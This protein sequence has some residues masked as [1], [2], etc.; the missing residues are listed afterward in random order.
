MVTVRTL[1]PQDVYCRRQMFGNSHGDHGDSKKTSKRTSSNPTLMNGYAAI[2][3]FLGVSKNRGP[4]ID[5]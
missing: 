2:L 3:T 1:P 4:N 5:L